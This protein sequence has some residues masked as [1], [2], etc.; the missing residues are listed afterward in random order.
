[1]TERQ[2]VAAFVLIAAVAL[3]ATVFDA[4]T[5]DLLAWGLAIVAAGALLVFSARELTIQLMRLKRLTP[6]ALEVLRSGG[7]SLLRDQQ[8]FL[9][10]TARRRDPASLRE[11]FR[12]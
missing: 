2:T 6:S 9:D 3:R 4:Q 7:F 5:L 1:M 12:T 11:V 8:R 10:E